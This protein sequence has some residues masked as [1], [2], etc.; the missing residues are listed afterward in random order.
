MAFKQSNNPLSRKTSPMRRSPFSQQRQGMT[1]A[2]LEKATAKQDADSKAQ[3]LKLPQIEKPGFDYEMDQDMSYPGG[4]RG[5]DYD[6]DGLKDVKKDGMS[7][8]E[9]PLNIE[10]GKIRHEKD[11]GRKLDGPTWGDHKQREEHHRGPE[12]GQTTPEPKPEPKPDGMSRMEEAKYF[13]LGKDD[14]KSRK[15]DKLDKTIDQL[16]GKMSDKKRKRKE[17]KL[18]KTAD[19]LGMSR[20]SSPLNVTMDEAYKKRDM[21]TY[22]DLS[23][24]EYT[25]EAN[26]QIKS[27]QQGKG[28]DAPKD[29]MQS[30]KVDPP[31]DDKVDPPTDDKVVKLD[32]VVVT[33]KK[34]KSR[35]EIKARK[36]EGK[37]E[38]DSKRE[39]RLR[40]TKDKIGAAKAK[41]ER[42]NEEGGTKESQRIARAKV[43]R[44]EKRE[45]RI[46]Q[47][48][49][50]KKNRKSDKFRENKTRDRIASRRK[51]KEKKAI[52]NDPANPTANA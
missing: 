29:K 16:S 48:E 46:S 36:A 21:D 11:L 40:K 9:S 17:K 22:G 13:G 38:G 44:L 5:R 27:K 1:M 47:R 41:A 15:E 42:T 10:G 3:A 34:D 45:N 51:Q 7:R 4:E 14:G 35:E 52:I 43:K 19:Q 28:Y 39:I 32:E 8:K 12:F 6:E 25:A 50:R 23:L 2:E 24:E 30:K 33:A 26:R 31:K 20:N 18:L 37:K 49:E